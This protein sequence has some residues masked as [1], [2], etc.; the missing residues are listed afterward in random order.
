M[1]IFFYFLLSLLQE[2]HLNIYSREEN[3]TLQ[4]LLKVD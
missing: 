4:L 1:N 3:V 2:N